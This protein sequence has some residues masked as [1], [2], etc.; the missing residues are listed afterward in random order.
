MLESIEQ[1]ITTVGK[2]IIETSLKGIAE[3]T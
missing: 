2:E 3:V 1:G